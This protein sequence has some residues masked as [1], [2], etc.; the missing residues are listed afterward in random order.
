MK[1]FSKTPYPSRFSGLAIG[2]FPIFTALWGISACGGQEENGDAC[3]NHIQT[4]CDC[5]GEEHPRCEAA[6]YSVAQS[7]KDIGANSIAAC[8]SAERL[9]VCEAEPKALS[10]ECSE[11][12]EKMCGCVGEKTFYCGQVKKI[13]AELTRVEAEVALKTC[14]AGLFSYYCGRP[15]Y[16]SILARA[17]C[18]CA[19]FADADCEKTVN[20]IEFDLFA[21]GAEAANEYCKSEYEA[22]YNKRPSCFSAETK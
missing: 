14:R 1:A 9:F 10:K 22:I 18:N 7:E 15:D 12:E 6:K 20:G 11:L 5:Y 4:V 16:C 8:M 19:E 21:N 2:L 3:K 17:I 13:I